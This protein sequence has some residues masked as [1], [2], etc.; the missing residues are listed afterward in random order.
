MERGDQSMKIYRTSRTGLFLIELI[1]SVFF[2]I[3]SCAI[4]VLLFAKSYTVSQEAVNFNNALRYSQNIAEL[5]LGDNGSFEAVRIAYSD[6]E[7]NSGD[8]F[9]LLLFDKD[10]EPVTGE[11][12]A[13]YSVWARSYVDSSFSYVNIYVQKYSPNEFISL[14][15]YIYFQSIKKYRGQL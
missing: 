7:Y 8:D 12:D 2:F 14:N 11:T 15:E 6:I 10:W 5:F 9:L 3:V 1:I 13:M 4:I